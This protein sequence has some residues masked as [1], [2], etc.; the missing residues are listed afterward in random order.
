MVRPQARE[1]A[2]DY[3]LTLAPS[4]EQVIDRLGR[5]AFES[6]GLFLLRQRAANLSL[7]QGFDK[8]LSLATV[9]FTPFPYQLET[10]HT[11]LRRFRGRALLCDEV[12]L[13]KTIEAGI[14]LKEYILRGLVR[15]V[16]ILTPPA[17]VSQWHEE[18]LEKFNLSFVTHDDPRFRQKG[19]RA[20]SEFDRVI[21]S[22]HTARMGEN[23]K[24]ILAQRYDLVIVDEAHHLRSRSA[25]SWQFVNDLNKKYILLLT[26]TPVQNSLEELFNLIT[27]LK[28][29]QLKTM[30][31]FKKEFVARGDPRQPKN[32]AR[33]HEL[34]FD[35]MVRN[36]RSQ[37]DVKLPK[38][39]ATTVKLSLTPAER[40]LYDAVTE[41][42]RVEHPRVG[43]GDQG[44]NRFTLETLQMEVGSSGFAVL[45]TLAKMAENPYNTEAQ[46]QELRRLVDLARGVRES[47]KATAVLKLLKASPEKTLVFT[48]YLATLHHLAEVLR[49]AGHTFVLYHGGLSAAQK[50]EAIDAFERDQR[51]LL[52][53]EAAGEGRNLQF[54]NTMINYDLPWNPM[55]IEQRIGRIHRIGQNREVYIYNLSA[56]GTVEDYVLW[57][58]DSK[59]NMFELVIGEM[60]MI[61]GNLADER[62]FEDIITDI[63]IRSSSRE[64]VQQRLEALG[65]DLVRAR[66]EYLKTKEYDER[67]FG[68]DYQAD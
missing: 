62:D 9:S 55:R 33:L 52:C 53:T 54:C 7:V 39:H 68:Q 2:R 45:P 28:P 51:V 61:L 64:E 8:L 16:L 31:G 34:L 13:G 43:H 3:E 19:A 65:E 37:V 35:V 56:E 6:E 40:H 26:A 47:S 42:V 38:R 59:I 49:Q 48:K 25:V 30:R 57:L 44:V 12:G 17:L 18:M 14:V 21:A 27:I 23:S 46:R 67:I 5:R 60:D 58:L 22:L 50:D 66:K 36:T 24:A 32:R 20:W 1:Q 29:G 15:K 41:F 63:W 10:A 11:A 4:N